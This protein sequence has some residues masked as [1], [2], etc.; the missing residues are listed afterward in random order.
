MYLTSLWTPARNAAASA[1]SESLATWVPPKRVVP[2]NIP[3]PFDK[4]VD[5]PVERVDTTYTPGYWN[6]ATAPFVNIIIGQ[7]STTANPQN[8]NAV[9][10]LVDKTLFSNRCRDFMRAVLQAASTK[11]NPVLHGG[12]IELIF[13]DF[14]GQSGGLSRIALKDAPYGSATG[15]LG[16]D[17]TIYSNFDNANQDRSDASTIINELPHIAGTKGGF[18][19]QE[20]DDFALAHATH[21]TS[22]G[23]NFSL[24]GNY[25]TDK[26]FGKLAGRPKNPFADPNAA[27]NRY[28][29]RWSNYF[30]NILR[31]ECVL[32]Q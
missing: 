18:P 7:S 8:P 29:S 12:D 30:H 11:N 2:I 13:D 9:I 19:R 10:S 6:Y 4:Y 16:K 20:Y 17:G 21:S 28:D 32:P 23:G 15:T 25:P 26:F 24:V 14:L 3:N 31:Q 22:Y 1:P 5:V 27:R